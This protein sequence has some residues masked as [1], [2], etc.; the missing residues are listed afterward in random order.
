LTDPPFIMALAAFSP[1]KP[2]FILLGSLPVLG[3]SI[4]PFIDIDMTATVFN[5]LTSIRLL[6]KPAQPIAKINKITAFNLSRFI[7][8]LLG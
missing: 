6:F 7:N 1:A 5:S 3:L 2:D 4:S 8:N